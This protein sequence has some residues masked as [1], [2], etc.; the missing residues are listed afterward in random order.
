MTSSSAAAWL[1]RIYQTPGV[2][3]YVARAYRSAFSHEHGL[4]VLQDLQKACY[5]IDTTA[6]GTQNRPLDP[7]QLAVN[8]G[9]RQAYLHIAGMLQVAG[10]ELTP[11]GPTDHDHRDERRDPGHDAERPDYE[12]R[13][14]AGHNSELDGPIP[15]SDSSSSSG[16]D[17]SGSGSGEPDAGREGGS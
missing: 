3:T 9:R 8:E 5:I 4:A 10:L 16:S 7:V 15:G 1:K 12:P 17:G 2:R 13:W 6:A 11:K 14:P